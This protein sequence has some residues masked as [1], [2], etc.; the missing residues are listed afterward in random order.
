MHHSYLLQAMVTDGTNHAQSGNA[1]LQ[2]CEQFTSAPSCTPK[3]RI[4]IIFF[5]TK[6]EQSFNPLHLYQDF[7]GWRSWKTHTSSS[8]GIS[9]YK[10]PVTPCFLPSLPVPQLRPAGGMHTLCCA[11][12]LK[13]ISKQQPRRCLPAW[14]CLAQ[15]SPAATP[16]A[17]SHTAHGAH[18]TP[19]CWAQYVA[20]LPRPPLLSFLMYHKKHTWQI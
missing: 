2:Q 4:R 10:M 17:A 11:K 1:A 14:P 20:R 16:S 15:P 19:L 12:E 9:L 6:R 8:Q 3:R 18:A 13:D 5:Y 7:V